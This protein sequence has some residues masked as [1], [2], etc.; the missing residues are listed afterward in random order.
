MYQVEGNIMNEYIRSLARAIIWPILTPEFAAQV[1]DGDIDIY[2]LFET[3][4]DI[5][6]ASYRSVFEAWDKADRPEYEHYLPAYYD[7]ERDP[8][9]RRDYIYNARL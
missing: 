5:V 7:L 4:D 6:G 3:V 8:D 9:T 2:N 1:V